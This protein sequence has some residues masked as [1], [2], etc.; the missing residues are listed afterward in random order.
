[1]GTYQLTNLR[2]D[3]FDS[4]QLSIRQRFSGQYEW[5]LASTRSRAVS[6]ALIDLA[7]REPLQVL[8]YLA[9]MPWDTPA[10]LVG[11]A[12]LPLPW[13]NWAFS[14]LSDVRSGYPYSVRDSYGLVQGSVNS[15]RYPQNFD[16]N[17]AI[18]RIVTFRGRRFALRGGVN[19]LTNHLNATA[20]NNVAGAPDFQKFLGAEGRHFVV[21][22]RFFGAAENPSGG[23]RPKPKAETSPAP[24]SGPHP[25]ASVYGNTGLW[26]VFTADTL[27]P[28][29]I[30]VSTWYDRINRNPGELVVSTLGF[31]GAIGITSRLELGASFEAH[32]DVTTG[33][34][35]ELSFGRRRLAISA[36]KHSALRPRFRTGVR[37][38]HGSS[39]ALPSQ[40]IWW[41]HGCGWLLR[42]ISLCRPRALGSAA[43][44]LFFGLKT[45]ILSESK[46][47]GFGLA[48]RPYFDLP[49]HKAIT[50]L[51]THPVGT[52]DL[53]GRS[54]RNC[55]QEHWRHGRAIPECRLPLRQPTDACQRVPSS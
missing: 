9:P 46:G 54:R 45:A 10:R 36:A 21:R 25:A 38:Q 49:I 8:P 6:N 43:G 24:E 40:P 4:V 32:R 17:L 12:Y 26:K 14:L 22:I 1:V 7:G 50:F 28:H 42:S 39:T 5:M 47:A 27:T 55:E 15:F 11:W 34:P 30:V 52:A 29:Q 35:D 41:S 16:L 2:R 51:E 37:Q 33:C 48:I 44:D 13:K 31:G 53:A 20:V 19:N 3:D 18:E 23:P